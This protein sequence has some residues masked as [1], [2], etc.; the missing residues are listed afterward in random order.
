M[1]KKIEI[2]KSLKSSNEIAQDMNKK[3][4]DSNNLMSDTMK[5]FGDV[6][7]ANSSYFCYMIIF[8]FVVVFF[9]FKI[10]T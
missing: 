10:T 3:Y 6:L 1:I 7:S 5:R 2:Q 4:S 9:L 8:V